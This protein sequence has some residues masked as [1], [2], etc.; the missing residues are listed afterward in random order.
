MSEHDYK[1]TLNLPETDFPMKASLAEREPAML[2]AWEADDVYGRIRRAAAGRPKFLLVDGPPYANGQIHLGHAVNKALKDMVVK[3]KTLSGFDAPYIPGWDCH[4]LPIELEVEKKHGKVGRKL[5]ATQF[6]EACRQ[7]ARAQVDSQRRDFRRLGVLGD[8]DRP[9]LTL[10]PAFEA[11]QVRGFARIMAN[12]HVQRGYKPVHWCLDC[13]SALAEAEVEYADRTSSAIDVRFEVVDR[14]DC[15]RRLALSPGAAL[16]L[17]IPI[18]TTTPWT[19]PANQAVALGPAHDYVLVEATIAGRRERLVLAEALAS[20]ALSR[21]GAGDIVQI[22]RF[23]GDALAGLLLQHPFCERQVPVITGEHVTL[24]AGTGAVHTAPGHGL[25]DFA[26]GVAHGLPLDNP[27]DG[28]GVFVAGTPRFAGMHI[29]EANEAIVATLAAEGRL[30]R[31]EKVVHSYPHCWRH[32]SPLI[33]RAT[34]QWFISL[35]RNGL[36]AAALDAIG[37][38]RWVP[39]WGRQRIE[40]MVAGRPDWC[41]SRQRA[42]GVPIPLFV[43]RSS[44]DVHPESPRLIEE[45]A[46]RMQQRGVDAWFDLDPRELLGADAGD[47]E[48]VSDTMDV[49]MDS[50]MVHHCLAAARPEVG[51]PAS[52]YLEG[53]DQHR[54]WFQS[55]LLT[56]VAMHGRAPY[57]AVLTHGFTV[58]EKGRKMSKSL[59][60]G[61]EPQ[62]VFSTLGADVLRLWVA[63]TDYRGEMSG[64]NEIL[65]RISES[66][67]RMRN[68]VRFLLGNLH[69]FDP[70]RHAVAVEELVDLDRWALAR[71]GE[72]QREILAAYDAYEFHRVYQLLHNFCVVDLGAFY[73]DVIKDRLYTT[74]REGAPR[75]SAQTAMYH[76]AEAMVRWLAPVLSFTAEEIWRALPGSRDTTVFTSTWHELPAPGAGRIDWPVLLRVRETAARALEALR[77]A[78]RIGSGLDAELGIYAD[79]ATGAALAGLGPELRFVFITSAAS[80]HPAAERP[81]EAMPGE[82]F[83]VAVTPATHEKCV[84]CWHRREDVGRNAA[85][86]QLCGRCVGNVEGPGERRACA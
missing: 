38:V 64:S 44:G 85:H 32:K 79:G 83:W 72:L 15:D 67:R 75:R 2:A 11:S 50:G 55:S 19:L 76:V 46:R 16:P 7:Y 68:T 40:S 74:P 22:A 27:V 42:W 36:R 9:Y 21:Y 56:S 6:R 48:K 81:A 33:F 52:L 1:A 51:F 43:H 34:P 84:R 62:R 60:N 29:K 69:G 18:W 26:A 82:G 39:D 57:E 61:I 80:V 4:G 77:V 25:E 58:D 12:G 3:S 66:Y 37:E 30:L 8:W 35:D 86:P 28:T 24:D 70:Q 59:G 14:A 31:A 49:W 53:S 23:H 63:A 65:K 20:A 5:D 78:G 47:Y 54:G 13:G 10:D 45:V 71:T 41:V 17:A 73:L